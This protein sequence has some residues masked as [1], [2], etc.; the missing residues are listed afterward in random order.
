MS[1]DVDI[2]SPRAI[3]ASHQDIVSKLQTPYFVT[4]LGPLVTSIDQ[5]DPKNR[6]GLYTI[7]ESERLFFRL[8]PASWNVEIEMTNTDHGVA[9]EVQAPLGTKCWSSWSVADTEGGCMIVERSRVKSF[10]PVALF[11]ARK[12]KKAHI[13]MLD[14]MCEILER[15]RTE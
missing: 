1:I 12:L 15:P 8:I 6:P 7:H 13:E 2:I 4:G 14:K 5:P 9:G 11:T 10:A 3:R